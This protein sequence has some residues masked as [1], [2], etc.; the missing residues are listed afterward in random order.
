MSSA[1]GGA[2]LS[3]VR[4]ARDLDRCIRLYGKPETI[5]PHNGT[6]RTSRAIL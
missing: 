4:V 5:V 1:G 6:E 3:G 2:Y